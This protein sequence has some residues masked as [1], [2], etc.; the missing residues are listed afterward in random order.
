MKRTERRPRY[1]AAFTGA[2]SQATPEA[3]FPSESPL[4]G[5]LKRGMKVFPRDIYLGLK[6]RI[7]SGGLEPADV[8][9][10]DGYPGGGTTFLRDDGSF[11]LP[12]GGVPAAHAPTHESG[13]TDPVDVK[14]LPGYPGGGTTFLRDDATFAV[15]VPGAALTKVDDTNVTATLGGTPSTALV[16][17]ASITLGWTG[18]L[19]IAR[20][21]TGQ[22]TQT[23]A[24]DALSPTT[25]KGD[26]PVDNGTNV[27]RLP[28]GATNGDVLT[29]DSGEA[30]G[31]KWAS[32]PG[33]TLTVE[34]HTG[35]DVLT[36]GETGSVHNNSGASGNV[37]LTLPAAAAGLHFYFQIEAAQK[38]TILPGAG[39]NIFILGTNAT[40]SIDATTAGH[41]VDLFAIDG[42]RWFAQSIVGTWNP[43]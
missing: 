4:Y 43:T 42:T 29:V 25:T 23:A 19:S 10:L 13:G 35:D 24:M 12:S 15:P 6:Q 9:A 27:V 38:L 3:G 22:S 5:R 18:Q 37:N 26:I 1:S 34:A 30:A 28:V 31:V 20:G 39:D 2:T 40:V 7:E 11:Q 41:A 14:D 8:T 17:A 32:P 36:S 33:G 21:G 16:R